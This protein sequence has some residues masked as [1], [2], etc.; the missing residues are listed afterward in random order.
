MAILVVIRNEYRDDMAIQHVVGYILRHAVAQDGYGLSPDYP[1]QCMNGLKRAWNKDTGS[2]LNH[3][4]FSLSP[5]EENQ[6][7]INE[8]LSF[9]AIFS[10]F[11]HEFQTVYAVHANTHHLHLHFVMNT[12]SFSCGRKYSGGYVPLLQFRDFL[13]HQYPRFQHMIYY[14]YPKTINEFREEDCEI[15]EIW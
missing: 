14:S 6:I 5:P 11:L 12:V 2:R 9:G 4:I 8:L 1:I 3:Y 13:Q 7:T 15:L 10:R